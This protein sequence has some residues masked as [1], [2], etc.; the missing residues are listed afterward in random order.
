MDEPVTVCDREDA[1][2]MPEIKGEVSF[3]NVTF[4]YETGPN[5]LENLSFTAKAGESI[6]LVGPT[7]NHHS[8]PFKSI[9]QLERR[10]N[11]H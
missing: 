9:L 7:E 4:A 1:K 5:I 6:A 3:N 2:E 11:R 8:E 10:R